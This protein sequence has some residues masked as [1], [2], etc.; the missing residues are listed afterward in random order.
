M[1][2][3]ESFLNAVAVLL[4]KTDRWLAAKLSES[5]NYLSTETVKYCLVFNKNYFASSSFGDL[6]LLFV[7]PQ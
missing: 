7:C 5:P 3:E 4:R 6:L 2:T 1:R